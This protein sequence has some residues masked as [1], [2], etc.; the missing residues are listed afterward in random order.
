MSNSIEEKRNIQNIKELLERVV[1]V[2][3]LE[4]ENSYLEG[5]D[6]NFFVDVPRNYNEGEYATNLPLVL[7]AFTFKKQSIDK[8]TQLLMFYLV[9]EEMFERVAVSREG[10]IGF[11]LKDEE[12]LPEFEVTVVGTYSK[13]LRALNRNEAEKIVMDQ[14]FD[15]AY[16]KE[17]IRIEVR[18]CVK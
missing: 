10:F 18:E 17:K 1:E 8:I 5:F 14:H 13:T 6:T 9:K 11:W 15:P 16:L 3:S 4:E 2:A 7:H 12:D